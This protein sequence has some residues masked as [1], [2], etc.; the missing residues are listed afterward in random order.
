MK[1]TAVKRNQLEISVKGLTLA[2]VVIIACVLAAISLYMVQRGKSTM[3]SGNN[4]YSVLMSDYTELDKTIYD[5]LEV[6]GDDVIRVIDQMATDSNVSVRVYTL[7]NP[8]GSG[9]GGKMYT[10]DSYSFSSKSD[11]DYINPSA[12][13]KGKVTKNENGI[14]V[15]ISFT[16]KGA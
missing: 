14:V 10:T 9:A 3:N 16:Q 15:G 13:F 4:Q 11:K 2:V 7:L 5:G 8:I 6:S 12:T 1:K